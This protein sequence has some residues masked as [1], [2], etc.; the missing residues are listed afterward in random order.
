MEQHFKR[1]NSCTNEPKVIFLTVA[2]TGILTEKK[3]V[4]REFQG[5][6]GN[7]MMLRPNGGAFT[8]M[9]CAAKAFGEKCPIDM[10]SKVMSVATCTNY[11]LN[12]GEI[13]DFS[14][15]SL[16]SAKENEGVPAIAKEN[17][18]HDYNAINDIIY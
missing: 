13:K 10:L 1:R 11:S 9:G 16:L 3:S 4:P 12:G 5:E 7:C 2:A 6:G 18:P 8:H 14:V 17:R 15:K